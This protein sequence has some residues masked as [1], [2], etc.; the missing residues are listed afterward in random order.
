MTEKLQAH[1]R[2][3]QAEMNL[4][5][6]GSANYLILLSQRATHDLDAV[7]GIGPYEFLCQ[8]A[9]GNVMPHTFIGREP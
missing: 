3:Y 2:F 9:D 5:R 1:V 4:F 6:A 7:G 8:P